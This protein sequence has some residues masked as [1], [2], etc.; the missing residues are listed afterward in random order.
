MKGN[1]VST[2]PPAKSHYEKR[3][4]EGYGLAY[5]DGHVIRGWE[6]YLKHWMPQGQAL[7]MLDFGCWNGTHARYFHD[8]G[9]AVAGVD[10]V[11]EP[12]RLAAEHNAPYGS[13]FHTITDDT[14]LSDLYEPGFDLIFSNQVLY[15]LD[16]QTLAKRQA[17][18]DALLGKGGFV[19]FSM[20]TRRNLF[21]DHSVGVRP[22][23]LEVIRF[24]EEHRFKGK[25]TYVRFVES[26]AHIKA[27]F[28]RF[29]CV[30]IGRY[31]VTFDLTESGEHLIFIGRKRAS[32]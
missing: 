23:G 12:V 24:P 31:D 10:I 32:V 8:K 15:F 1:A 14:D 21:N 29:D 20:M 30:A 22:D 5:P 19:F 18:F 9:F 3:A 16:D 17:E 26:P 4:K 27:L 7:R 6:N 2:V 13:D 25:E 28:C 11:D